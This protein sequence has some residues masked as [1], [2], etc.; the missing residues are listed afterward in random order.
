MLLELL[1]WGV[2]LLSIKFS[3]CLPKIFILSSSVP[4]SLWCSFIIETKIYDILVHL[5]GHGLKRYLPPFCTQH[6]L[7]HSSSPIFM[8]KKWLKNVSRQ[9][10]YWINSSVDLIPLSSEI[11]TLKCFPVHHFLILW[12]NISSFVAWTVLFNLYWYNIINTSIFFSY[13]FVFHPKRYPSLPVTFS[14]KFDIMNLGIYMFLKYDIFEL[15]YWI[16][17]WY[18]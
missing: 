16:Y 17:T 4:F 7:I 6:I 14:L 8:D 13:A 1:V 18:W 12:I 5:L 11:I 10:S 2:K 3:T 15:W 9:M